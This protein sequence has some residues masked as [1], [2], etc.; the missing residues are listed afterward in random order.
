[1]NQQVD[2]LLKLEAIEKKRMNRDEKRSKV[3]QLERK[4]DEGV[5]RYYRLRQERSGSALAAIEDGICLGCGMHY[6]DTNHIIQK[7]GIEFV[8]CEFCG[9]ILFPAPPRPKKKQPEKPVEAVASVAG[10]KT[11]SPAPGAGQS[12]GKSAAAVNTPKKKVAP[13]P[14]KKKI[15]EKK[16][17]KKKAPKKKVAKKPVKK[18]PARKKPVRK[19]VVRKAAPKKVTRKKVVKKKV[20]K[21]RPAKKRTQKKVVKK[22]RAGKPTKK[23][24]TKKG[25]TRT[26]RKKKVVR[27]KPSRKPAA[28]KKVAKKKGAKKKKRSVGGNRRR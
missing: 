12:T 14:L 25:K 15:S 28:M 3:Q 10:G 2:L 6:P 24:V 22:R 17:T 21:K 19:K 13:E 1:M 18:R 23:K 20:A 27:K 5:L 26:A 16:V 11:K 7:L 8:W 9:R 4:I